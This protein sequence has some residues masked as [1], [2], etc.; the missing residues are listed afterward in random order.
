MKVQGNITDRTDRFHYELH[1][2]IYNI[3]SHLHYFVEV[4]VLID[5][6]MT[7]SVNGNNEIAKSGQGIFIL[8][9]QEHSY[10]SKN[11]SVFAIFSFSSSFIAEFLKRTSGTIG[12]RAVFNLSELTLEAFKERL[13]SERDFSFYNI[14]ACLYLWLADYIRQVR[15]VNL[16]VRSEVLDK[17]VYYLNNNYDK[18]CLLS[19]TASAIGYTATYISKTIHGLFNINYNA[20][21]N[22]IRV[23]H[24]KKL[25]AETDQTI[26]SVA[27]ECGF[28]DA[29][30][31]QRSFKKLTGM[32]PVEYRQRGAS[33]REVVLTN[34]IFPISY[35][36]IF[37]DE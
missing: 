25:L 18:P 20:F 8:P 10:S 13:I 30:S 4:C 2:E 22:G 26:L 7:I 12:E 21:L 28:N 33:D 11:E 27:L 19:E 34:H 37:P 16:R 3:G 24:A 6:E 15:F 5:G 1:R 9:F 29:R 31:L 17:L 35:F 14:K 36:E 23:E 32:T